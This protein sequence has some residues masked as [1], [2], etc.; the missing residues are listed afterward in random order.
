M[1]INH[2]KQKLSGQLPTLLKYL[3]GFKEKKIREKFSRNTVFF[4]IPQT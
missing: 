1:I 4:L 2:E 3:C